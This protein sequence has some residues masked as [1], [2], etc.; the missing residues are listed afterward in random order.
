MDCEIMDLIILTPHPQLEFVTSFYHVIANIAGK[1][2]MCLEGR[3]NPKKLSINTI[4]IF[5]F[6]SH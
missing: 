2:H 1:N 5:E 3:I 4:E 6:L